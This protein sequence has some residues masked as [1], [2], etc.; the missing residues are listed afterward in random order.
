[1]KRRHAFT[2][3]E[4]LVV[5][6]I[7]G[8]LVAL[9]LP[10]VQAAREAGRRTQCA[11][12]LKQI[13]IAIH[14]HHDTM[15]FLPSAGWEWT[16]LPTFLNGVPRIAPDQNGSWAFQIL[17]YLEQGNVYSAGSITGTDEQK[18]VWVTGQ[19]ID[20]YFCPSRHRPIAALHNKGSNTRHN[21]VTISV[22][23]NIMRGGFDYA[24]TTQDDHNWWRVNNVVV[25]P[26]SFKG[27]GVFIRTEGRNSSR[28]HRM[29]LEGVTDGTANVIA[30][31]EKRLRPNEYDIGPWNNDTGYIT[32]WDGD[33]MTMAFRPADRTPWPPLPDTNP[34]PNECCS[35]SRTGSNHPAAMNA[36]LTDGSVRSVTYTINFDTF[37]GL[38]YRND[39]RPIEVPQ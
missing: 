5:I 38:L 8:I 32:G 13:G 22:S 26:A 10:A 1:M 14:N 21:Y 37:V 4:L 27:H 36:L 6:A 11:N 28:R 25:V 35:G 16:E 18:A 3:V 30:V 29:G 15:K 23:T 24:G 12:N 31:T 33:T 2:L 17:P 19:K 34:A 39:G 7:I 20:G 9:L